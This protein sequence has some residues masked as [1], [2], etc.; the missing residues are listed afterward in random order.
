M[1]DE[2]QQLEAG[3]RSFD[4]FILRRCQILLASARG[5]RAPR[6]A[7]SVG[8]SGETVRNVIAAFNEAGLARLHQGSS[9]PHTMYP[10]FDPTQAEKVC[11]LL[12][13][14]PRNFAK[15]T[16]LW[17]LELA[18]RVCFEQGITPTRGHGRDHSATLARL[19]IRWLRAKRWITSPDPQY[20]RKEGRAV[21]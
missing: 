4:A 13:Q 17:T 21:A 14:G 20:A 16:S 11:A 6:I 18:A 15:P 10:A 2:R 7:R 12:H 19:G 9:V 5:E 3:L 8:C 1:D